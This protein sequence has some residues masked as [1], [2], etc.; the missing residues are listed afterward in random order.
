MGRSSVSIQKREMEKTNGE[1][2]VQRDI[3]AERRKRG[4]AQWQKMYCVIQDKH[5]LYIHHN[6]H[7]YNVMQLHFW[8]NL[9]VFCQIRKILRHCSGVCR[10]ADKN[11]ETSAPLQLK[12]PQIM[13]DLKEMATNQFVVFAGQLGKPLVKFQYGY[14]GHQIPETQDTVEWFT[15]YKYEAVRSPVTAE[16]HLFSRWLKS[17]RLS[18]LVSCVK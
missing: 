16:T 4:V 15:C 10:I 6:F 11:Q 8:S 18:S 9:W 3:H 7:N 12:C 13:T 1:K 2:W 5:I 14:N 17:C